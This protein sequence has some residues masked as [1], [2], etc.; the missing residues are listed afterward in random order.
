MTGTPDFLARMRLPAQPQA[1]P[2]SMVYAGHARFTVLTS[3][4][5]RLEWSENGLFEDRGSLAF[6]HRHASPPPFRA[7]TEQG[8]TTI[9]TDAL[10][11]RYQH[12]VGPFSSQNLQITL[13]GAG[14]P[15]TWRPG[16]PNGGNLGGTASTLDLADGPVGLGEGLISRD[17]WALVDDSHS[18]LLN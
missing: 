12:E 16:Q 7:T 4:L 6:P 10:Q 9:T 2:A 14:T 1:H 11:V 18:V 13:F 5:L 15:R 8:V 17:G 3:R